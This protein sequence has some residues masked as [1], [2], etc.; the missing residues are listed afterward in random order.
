MSAGEPPLVAGRLPATASH[1]SLRACAPATAGAVAA[2]AK[3]RHSPAASRF[4]IPILDPQSR[5]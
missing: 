3:P 4:L 2:T 5:P 1:T